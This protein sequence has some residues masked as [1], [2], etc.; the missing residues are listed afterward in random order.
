M[1]CNEI[2]LPTSFAY[3]C[4]SCQEKSISRGKRNIH[5]RI[6]SLESSFV[7]KD[8]KKPFS[9]GYELVLVDE[10]SHLCMKCGAIFINR[11]LLEVHSYHH[12]KEYPCRCDICSRASTSKTKLPLELVATEYDKPFKCDICARVFPKKDR[13]KRHMFV[14]NGKWPYKCEFCGK[15]WPDKRSLRIHV[16]RHTKE[17]PYECIDC[18]T[19]FTT[20]GHMMKH[21]SRTHGGGSY[22]LEIS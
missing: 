2:P 13:L 8:C 12:S 3:R 6:S 7:C 14:H 10:E 16:R 11:E 20:K 5:P 18:G 15:G 17:Q 1:D 9:L 21:F 4:D 19:K 22:M